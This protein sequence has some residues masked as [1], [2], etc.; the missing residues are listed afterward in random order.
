VDE[1]PAAILQG[2]PTHDNATDPAAQSVLDF[3][4]G[5]PGSADFGT[6]RKAWFE[7]D[8]AFDAEIA[9]HFG[10]QI[11]AALA[12]DLQPWDRSAEGTLARIV[13]LD[14]FTRNVFRG[15]ARAFAGDALAL[16]AAQA[17]VA[18]GGDALLR[19]EQRVFAYL[20]FEHAEQL[21]QQDTSI[22]LFAALAAAHAGFDTHL[23]YAHRHRVIIE[24]FGRYPHRNVLLGRANTAEE[25]AFLQQPGSGF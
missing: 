24:R 2:M 13:L 14:Q 6:I 20:P 7:K 5:A 12:G 16:D 1:R 21:A 4:F 9:R 15:T 18:R 3:W 17:L 8:A 11:E 19:P 22:R 23:A 10:A 25:L